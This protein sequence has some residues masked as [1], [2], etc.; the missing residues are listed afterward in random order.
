MG[1]KTVPCVIV[2]LDEESEKTLNLALNK[3]KG[4]WD[5]DKLSEILSGFDEEL[6]ELSGFAADELALMLGE[7]EAGIFEN[8]SD[9]WEDD[10]DS[11]YGSYV[12]TLQFENTYFAKCWAEKNGY[13][14]KIRDGSQTTVIRMEEEQ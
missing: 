9:A 7:N 14:R 1:E 4:E 11:I 2:D 13:P 12:V 5:Y 3:I 10:Q 8:V 6:A